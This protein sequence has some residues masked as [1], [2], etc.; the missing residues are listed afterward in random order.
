VIW[1]AINTLS[2]IRLTCLKASRV[3]HCRM[4]GSGD[5]WTLMYMS[6]HLHKGTCFHVVD[7]ALTAYT[8]RV[9]V[10]VVL[11]ARFMRNIIILHRHRRTVVLVGTCLYELFWIYAATFW[12]CLREFVWQ[13]AVRDLGNVTPSTAAICCGLITSNH[14]RASKNF[15]VPSLTCERWLYLASILI[16]LNYFYPSERDKLA[17]L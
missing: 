9:C 4:C 14:A 7:M 6:T 13:C 11:Y 2:D 16:R 15:Y 3:E 12:P 1:N 5:R 10:P 17:I 8:W